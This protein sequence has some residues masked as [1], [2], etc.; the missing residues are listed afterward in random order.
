MLSNGNPPKKGGGK[1]TLAGRG[2]GESHSVENGGENTLRGSGLTQGWKE[3]RREAVGGLYKKRKKE[4]STEVS[5]RAKSLF[6]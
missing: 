4:R 3:A 6:C 2:K 1:A 5:T